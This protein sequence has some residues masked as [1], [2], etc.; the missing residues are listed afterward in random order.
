MFLAQFL[1]VR[2]V[3]NFHF[4]NTV[5]KQFTFEWCTSSDS[6]FDW[7]ASRKTKSSWHSPGNLAFS[8]CVL[9]NN[10]RW[11]FLRTTIQHMYRIVQ[12][13]WVIRK[14]R[15]FILQN[16]AAGFVN[17]TSEFVFCPVSSTITAL[18][19]QQATLHFEHITS[20]LCQPAFE[21][22]ACVAL[23][24]IWKYCSILPQN[25]Q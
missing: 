3:V 4:Q 13:G 18:Q 12:E 6:I 23:R 2:Y 22:E 5:L 19:K 11:A 17:E 9:E 7:R 25:K 1:V 15:H 8:Y 20:H 21:W 16:I 24:E 10:L 14:T